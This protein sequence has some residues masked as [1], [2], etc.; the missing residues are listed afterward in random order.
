MDR[1]RELAG[2]VE[3][4]SLR[5]IFGETLVATPASALFLALLFGTGG[6]ALLMHQVMHGE[7]AERV[8]ATPEIMSAPNVVIAAAPAPAEPAP[9]ASPVDLGP[10]RVA[11]HDV[12]A[13]PSGPASPA[14]PP[15]ADAVRVA[16]SGGSRNASPAPQAAAVDQATNRPASPARRVS[17]PATEAPILTASNPSGANGKRVGGAPRTAGSRV[18][19]APWATNQQPI[20]GPPAVSQVEYILDL[21]DVN[22]ERVLQLPASAVVSGSTVTF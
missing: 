22:Q 9:I 5:A 16:A 18:D 17:R 8:A 19:V 12:A 21:V 20:E 3:T 4:P 2:R 7:L 1:V 15:A 13:L 6:G 10:A 14:N 11:T